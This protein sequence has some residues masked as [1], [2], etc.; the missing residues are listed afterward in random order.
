MLKVL[1]VLSDPIEMNHVLMSVLLL[2]LVCKSRIVRNPM[3]EEIVLREVEQG[4]VD[5]ND[6]TNRVK[7]ALDSRI[8]PMK[9]MDAIGRGLEEVGRKYENGEYFLMELML[10]GDMAKELMDMISASYPS[11]KR[12][13][14][15]KVVIGTV[16][17]D[18]HDIGKNLVAIMLSSAGFE[19]KDLGTD[20]SSEKFVEAVKRER[21]DILALS[22]LLTVC[23][24]QFRSVIQELTN[25]G[26]RANIRIIA[27]GRP[28]TQQFA[29]EIGADA[30]GKDAVDAIT[31][32]NR[33]L[34]QRAIQ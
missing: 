18:I 31:I 20:V 9:I 11:D 32:C 21:P 23:L 7:E 17:G 4:I 26:L 22:G 13:R 28:I 14:R 3:K 5:L 2:V 24:D 10:V 6:T 30:Y 8:D 16:E 15:G 19:V 29:E 12:P 27:G 34:P 1:E 25:A 33:L